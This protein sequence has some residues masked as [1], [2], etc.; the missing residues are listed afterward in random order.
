MIEPR[1]RD[2]IFHPPLIPAD[3]IRVG[4]DQTTQGVALATFTVAVGGLLA[5]L[6][7]SVGAAY[8]LANNLASHV[9]S[10]RGDLPLPE[11]MSVVSMRGSDGSHFIVINAHFGG[12]LMGVRISVETAIDL[13]KSLTEAVEQTILCSGPPQGSA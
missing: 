10:G 7:L 4:V 3:A 8:A 11:S 13:A 1:L 2:P 12:V 5:G 9:K 6:R